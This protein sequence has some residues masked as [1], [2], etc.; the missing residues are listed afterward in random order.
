MLVMRLA[1]T[2]CERRSFNADF[3]RRSPSARLYS[4]VPRSSQWPSIR[5][6]WFALDFSHEAFASR[7]FA[8]SAPM[9]YLSKSK[10]MSFSSATD[11]NSPG[12]GRTVAARG[13]GPGVEG[14][15]PPG[16]VGPAGPDGPGPAAAG[17][18]AGGGADADVVAGRFAQP[19]KMT[20]TSTSD[21]IVRFKRRVT[22][23]PPLIASRAC[24]QSLRHRITADAG[25]MQD[26][27]ARRAP[28]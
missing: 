13:A 20:A 6:R 16:P 19:T 28:G 24:S 21:I 4:L 10:W 11:M 2:R 17:G 26:L 15:G 9:S 25:T 3:A 7:T 8:S 18:E 22:M 14:G 5:T 12:A 23:T 1:C 27:C